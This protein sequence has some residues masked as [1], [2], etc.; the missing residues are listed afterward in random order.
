[1]QNNNKKKW[2]KANETSSTFTAS[3]QHHLVNLF[4]QNL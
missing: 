2:C 3:H 4:K 1:M